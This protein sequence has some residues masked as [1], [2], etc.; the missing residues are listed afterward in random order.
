MRKQDSRVAASEQKTGKGKKL[1]LPLA[2]SALALV[3]LVL[4]MR[5]I[6]AG[7]RPDHRAG[8]PAVGYPGSDCTVHCSA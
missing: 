3:V 7:L 1:L 5:P 8:G 4:V 6:A 2:F